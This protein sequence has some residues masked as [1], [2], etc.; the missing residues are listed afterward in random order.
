ME[1]KKI[2]FIDTNKELWNKELLK[3]SGPQH[4]YTWQ[5]LSYYSTYYNHLLLLHQNLNSYF[6]F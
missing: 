1:F 4:L 6:T 5:N 3:V 2:N